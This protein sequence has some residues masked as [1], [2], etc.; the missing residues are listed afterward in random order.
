MEL[1]RNVS[2]NQMAATN[3]RWWRR[4]VNA[5]E[6]KAGMVYLQSKRLGVR[7]SRWGAIGLQIFVPLPYLLPSRILSR[8]MHV[9][10]QTSGCV[11]SKLSPLRVLQLNEHGEVSL[12]ELPDIVVT[13]CECLH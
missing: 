13:R 2:C 8:V 5:Y 6:V 3:L 11:P 1:T 10:T 9:L 7:L 4:P 12:A